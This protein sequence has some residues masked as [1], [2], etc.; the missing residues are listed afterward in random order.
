[1]PI[2][3]SFYPLY[4]LKTKTVYLWIEL[5]KPV[6]VVER[7]PKARDPKAPISI[8]NFEGRRGKMAAAAFAQRIKN[9][10]RPVQKN[11]PHIYKKKI[12]SLGFKKQTS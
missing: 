4:L 3:I 9:C 1:M 8:W 2:I 5:E 10:Y 6:V 11:D 7:K 12:M